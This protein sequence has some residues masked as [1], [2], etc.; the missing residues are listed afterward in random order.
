[1]IMVHSDNRGLVLPPRVAQTQVVF[2]PIIKKDDDSALIIG[3]A[4]ELSKALK[5]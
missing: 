3:K 2:V 1:M 5:K 4:N